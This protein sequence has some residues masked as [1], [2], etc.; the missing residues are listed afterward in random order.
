M[1]FSLLIRSPYEGWKNVF[2]YEKLEGMNYI[3]N[4]ELEA[5]VIG[6]NKVGHEPYWYV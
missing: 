5:L 4:E 2:S 1:L 6:T 3:A